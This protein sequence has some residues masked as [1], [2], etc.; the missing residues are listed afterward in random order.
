MKE[1]SVLFWDFDGV[2]KE[3]V[4]VKADAFESL[5]APFGH[6]LAV[7]VRQHHERNGGLSRFEKIPVYLRWAGLKASADEVSRYCERFS[8]AARQ[9]VMESAWVPGAREYLEANYAYQR[10][11]LVTA[12][13]QEEIDD[14]LR[15]LQIAHWF[16]EVHGAPTEKRDA[17]AS[18]LR[19]WQCPRGRALVIGDSE[20]DHDAAV[21]T[22]VDFL[23]RRTVLNQ[24][25][26]R[27]YQG[28]QCEDFVDG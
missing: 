24:T 22:G 11:V 5:F 8:A 15:D 1:R 25:L 17:I 28:P 9:A 18:V 10:F 2:I 27:A 23:L 6:G 20:S 16:R 14:I 4:A 7:R 3:S 13:P 12:T 26:Q 21:A 19:R